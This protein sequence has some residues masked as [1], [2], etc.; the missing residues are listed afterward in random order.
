[1]KDLDQWAQLARPV[2]EWFQRASL[3]IFIHWG[4]YSVPAWAEPTGELGTIEDERFWF[5]HNPYAEW[6]WN[7]ISI[8]GSPAQDHHR[9]T[10]GN[11]PYDDFLDSWKAERFDPEGL[12][13]LIAATGAEYVVPTSKHH[14]GIALW[15][16]P[17]TGSRNTVRRGPGRDLIGEFRT[18]ALRRGLKFGVY[19]SGGLDW[20]F[21]PTMPHL[22]FESFH[23]PER[24]NGADYARYAAEHVR[25]LIR[26]YSP[27]VLWNDI[28][29][30]ESGKNFGPD[31][32][33]TVFQQYYA[34]CP[35]GVVNDRWRVPHF[36]F[37]SSEYQ[38]GREVEAGPLWEHTRG[39][40]LSFGYNRAEIP[41]HLLTGRG[42][43]RHLAD[44][45]SRGGRLLLNVGL[46]A[47]GT[48]PAAQRVV[49]AALATWMKIAKPFLAGAEPVRVPSPRLESPGWLR[50]V[51]AADGS[52]ICFVDS[53]QEAGTVLLDGENA[54]DLQSVEP[55]WSSVGR[56]ASGHF[57][58]ELAEG[59]PGPAV[60]TLTPTSRL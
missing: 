34:A 25:D 24:P 16:A 45:V 37:A 17:G 4:A 44:V 11:A 33:G 59:R 31:G 60:L 12:L 22:T 50:S 3:G 6:Y 26:R 23:G 8:D 43:A 55:A 32:L 57:A 15:D 19:Y 36:D 48:L 14:D 35:D 30:P 1:M 58:I 53:E 2:P 52:T 54:G 5:T 56:N 27:A 9:R 20:H 7:T 28:Q 18:A 41:E 49:L 42:A 29:W 21:A 10:F 13:D 46:R 39:I 38:S 51:R 40:G 47:D